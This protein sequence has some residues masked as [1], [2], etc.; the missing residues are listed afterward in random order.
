MIELVIKNLNQEKSDKFILCILKEHE[1]KFSISKKIINLQLPCRVEFYI[2]DGLKD[3][4]AKTSYEAKNNINLNE[5]LILTNCDQV[6]CNYNVEKFRQYAHKYDYDGLLGTFFSRSP[7]NSFVK[8]N[9]F[10]D[11]TEVKEKVVLSE[12]ASNGFH[13]WKKAAD[14]FSSCEEMFEKNDRTLNEFYI[15]PSY[16]YLINKGKKIG[17]YFFNEH[18]PI[19]TPEDLQTYL[20]HSNNEKLIRNIR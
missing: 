11:V 18:F 6:I 15:A 4:P 8:L 3:G 1:E 5:E 17:H 2:I 7:K 19:G 9:D 14:L 12:F 20:K 13:Y 16:N 10:C